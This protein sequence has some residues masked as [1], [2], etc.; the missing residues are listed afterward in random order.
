M[1]AFLSDKRI[2]I[3][4]LVMFFGVAT[5][6]L[7]GQS[8]YTRSTKIGNQTVTEGSSFKGRWTL[9][10]GGGPTLFF[11][12][13]K[14]Y[15]YYPVTNY[16]SEWRFGGNL[17]L[18]R[19]ISP[20]F[21]IRGQGLYSELAGTRRA[22]KK[23]FNSELIEFNLSTAVNLNNLIGGFLRDKPISFHVIFG[24]GLLNYNT[25]VYELGSNK[26]VSTLGFG[27]G[28]GI[29]GRTLEGLLLGGFGV[30]IHLNDNWAIRLESANRG[31]N[32]DLLDN[33]V[34]M[35]KYDV[36]NHTSLGIAYTFNRRIGKVKLVPE[37]DQEIVPITMPQYEE[38]PVQPESNQNP[39]GTNAFNRV[40]DVLDVEAP[41]E[42]KEPEIEV[43]KET[44]KPQYI[45]SDGIEYRVQI[46]A[47]YGHKIST[48]ELARSYNL[49][50]DEIME[51]THKGYFIYTIGNFASYDEAVVKRN[52][53]RSQNKVYDAFI[54]AFKNGV[55][56]DKLP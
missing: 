32:S 38:E 10:V 46:R 36:Y 24:I 17:M 43:V 50:Q 56:L 47:R 25:T 45:K 9:S 14:Q 41:I 20:V 55:R 49:P 11:G 13:M 6:S 22:W 26:T 5:S 52:S 12:D 2:V 33:Y 4:F 3:S 23:Y 31:I 18:E 21:S 1:R 39:Q 53:I 37:D 15:Q 40:I 16:E 54:V 35:F 28:K 30:D 27:N 34:N 51:S 29:G 48:A 7:S 44:P 19:S 8:T 42:V